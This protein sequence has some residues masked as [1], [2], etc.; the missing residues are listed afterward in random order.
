LAFEI[1]DA[2]PRQSFTDQLEALKTR[3]AQLHIPYDSNEIGCALT[4]ALANRPSVQHRF[5]GVRR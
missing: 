2:D 5:G 3:A 1:I 4:F